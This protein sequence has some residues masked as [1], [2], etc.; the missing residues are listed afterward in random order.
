M[1]GLI[2]LIKENK[3]ICKKQGKR[4]RHQQKGAKLNKSG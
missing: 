1:H 4:G 3:N 2:N